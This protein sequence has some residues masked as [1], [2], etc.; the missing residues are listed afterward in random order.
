MVASEHSPKEIAKFI[1][2]L[3]G[4]TSASLLLTNYFG[5]Q[6][7]SGFMRW[8]M[9]VFFLVF[10]AFKFLGYAMF[11]EMFAGYDVVARRSS[12]YAKLYP[13]IELSLGLLYVFDLGSTGRDVVTLLIMAVSSVGVYGEIR[14]R[15]GIHCACLGNIIK[16]PL[17]TVS[18]VED[19]GM[20]LMAIAM[21]ALR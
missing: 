10:A 14:K 11:V 3:L 5:P 1:L 7:F 13:F 17:S 12:L 8:F 16:L 20:A 18:L 2:V 21:L 4:I 6:T 9:G 15:S 19:A